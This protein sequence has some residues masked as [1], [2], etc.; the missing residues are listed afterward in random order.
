M[1]EPATDTTLRLFEESTIR[2]LH[3]PDADAMIALLEG[4]IS[5][6]NSFMAHKS[7]IEP[8]QAG[9]LLRLEEEIIARL[10]DERSK[11]LKGLDELAKNLKALKVY[12]PKF[13]FP[14]M[15]VFFDK[16]S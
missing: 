9:C 11:V 14:S 15:P 3:E 6:L 13:P 12:S 16:T 4:R 1:E 8:E 2:A 5:L 10:E 7:D